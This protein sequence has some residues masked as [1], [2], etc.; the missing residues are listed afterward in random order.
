MSKVIVFGSL[1]MDLSIESDHMPN[2]GETI[3]GRGFITNPGGKGANQA[4]AAAKMA[5]RCACW[6]PW[7]LTHSAIR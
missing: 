5:P 4:V 6:V 1:N 3:I 2:L 7:A